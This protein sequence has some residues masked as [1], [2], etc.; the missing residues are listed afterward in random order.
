ML[1]LILKTAFLLFLLFSIADGQQKIT[2]ELKLKEK[3]LPFGLTEYI[4]QNMPSVGVALSGG[5]ARG[6]A[7]LG[8]LK[9]LNE[10]NIPINMIVG[11]SMGSI[12]G[13]LVASGYSFH[14]LDSIVTST[15]WTDF[16]SVDETDRKEL[17]VDQK[18]TEDKA[19]FAFR[20]KGLHLIIPT[21]LNTGQRV[22]NFLSLLTLN[23]P[24]HAD[25]GFN[26]LLYK[27]R[28]VSTDLVTGNTIVLD[29]GSLSQ[30][31]RASASV[32]FLLPPVKKD[33]LLLVDGG[34]VANIPVD[35]THNL[36]NNYIIASNTA[37]PLHTYNELNYP[38]IIADQIVS[39]PMKILNEQQLKDA[40]VVITPNI[41][42]RIN[43]DFSNLQ[44]LVDIGYNSTM[45]KIDTIK[46]QVDSLTEASLDTA[47]FFVKH[48]FVDKDPNEL[49]KIFFRKFWLRDS[50][51]NKELLM[52]LYNIYKQGDYKKLSIDLFPEN[53]KTLLKIN[54]V[55]NP[56]VKIFDIHGISLLD[57]EDVY[58]RLNALLNRPFNSQKLLD[59][60]ID[61]MQKYRNK[62][63]SLAEVEKVTFDPASGVVSLVFN[64]GMISK[65]VVKGNIKTNEEVITREMPIHSGEYFK[66]K[67]VEQGLINLRS[68][69][70]FDDVE[71]MVDNEN[72]KNILTIAVN[73]KIS[74]VFRFGMRIDNENLTQLSFDIR[75]ENFFGTGT[76]LGG[77][78]S[79]GV[80]NRSLILEHKANRI[81]DTYLT[82]K[83]R[84]FYEF[85]DVNVYAND[86]TVTG[87]RYKRNKTGE[88]RQ[89]YKG[90]SIGIGAQV[91]KF[92]NV[93]A[94]FK[95]EREEL[96]NKIDYTGPTYK[97]NLATLRLSMSIDSQ[98]KY[99][100]P[101]KGFLINGYYETAQTLLGSD[102]GFT[103]LS[104]DYK[105]IFSVS[106][107]STFN[108]RFVLG[109]ADQTLPLTQQFSLGGQNNFFGLRDNEYRGRQIFLSSLGYR[110]KLP[111]PIFFDAYLKARY[112][113]GSI[114]TNREQ[115]RFKDLRHGVGASLSI[116]TPL[117]PADFSIGRSFYFR[118]SSSQS[119]VVFGPV[120]LYFTIGYYY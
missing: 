109:L 101:T 31:M 78:L 71:V 61:I 108:A 86:S 105:S 89:I 41:K 57:K 56:T 93:I 100:Y 39:I 19:I 104:F 114:W 91:E 85:N 90:G 68:T 97:M 32:S 10:K 79:G 12:I 55:E 64:E 38:W 45:Q 42:G 84:G 120:F 113:L 83:I 60:V 29:N 13:G 25:S 49:E 44:D 23:A 107:I 118:N 106:D 40:N 5:G 51:S 70:L 98:D 65:V 27:F 81:F 14:Q 119:G 73:E 47:K 22:S 43:T 33:S 21:S 59:A 54:I 111:F 16:F 82:Y 62:G 116:D 26:N 46:S 94:E 103:K 1:R 58:A 50:V 99:P 112:D 53:D 24:I 36:G 18:I 75:D 102:L 69:N 37:S 77:I 88:Y 4:P 9:A 15:N 7:Q 63:Y 72:G 2:L 67:E 17:F 11:T 95:Y 20:L 66:Y 74:T 117:G 110:V 8:V 52:E 34:L 48:I 87:D 35:L 30:A 115:I 3:T 80:R 92:G 28:A 96:K 76:E 6:I